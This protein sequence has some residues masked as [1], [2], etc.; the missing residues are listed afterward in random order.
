LYHR[1]DE[2]S[3]MTLAYFLNHMDIP[4]IARAFQSFIWTP[5][6]LSIEKLDLTFFN[7]AIGQHMNGK[8]DNA[9]FRLLTAVARQNKS[10]LELISFFTK[11][12]NVCL[13]KGDLSSLKFIIQTGGVSLDRVSTTNYM[14]LMVLKK[15]DTIS[16][17]INSGAPV[18]ESSKVLIRYLISENR[19]EDVKTLLRLVSDKTPQNLEEIL[20]YTW[21]IVVVEDRTEIL[22]ELL[23]V[24]HLSP[25]LD[26]NMALRISCMRNYAKTAELLFDCGITRDEV[27]AGVFASLAAVQNSLDVLK[28][29]IDHGVSIKGVSSTLLVEAAKKGNLD[30]LRVVVENGEA[31]ISSVNYDAIRLAKEAG[32]RDCWEYLVMQAQLSMQQTAFAKTI[33]RD[34]LNKTAELSS[35]PGSSSRVWL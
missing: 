3:N 35:I 23:Q 30:M 27:E 24:Y 5:N 11:V 22:R 34:F 17:L 15:T 19:Y 10:S 14:T 29:F 9:A 18:H 13:E 7:S 16:F 8:E 31:D 26:N 20:R 2:D 6:V 21:N 33:F 28:C 25:R 12:F 1:F 4:L 32:H